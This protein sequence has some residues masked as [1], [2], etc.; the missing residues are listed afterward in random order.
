MDLGGNLS[1]G[2]QFSGDADAVGQAGNL[3]IGISDGFESFGVLDRQAFQSLPAV[4]DLSGI[5]PFVLKRDG[6]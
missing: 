5:G 3:S 1:V 6:V 4:V 2:T